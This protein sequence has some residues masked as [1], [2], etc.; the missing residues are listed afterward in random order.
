[1]DL[2]P[3]EY[4]S[5]LIIDSRDRLSGTPFDF[6]VPKNQQ[7]INMIGINR[8]AADSYHFSDILYDINLINNY[9]Q[10]TNGVN[11]YNITIPQGY[12]SFTAGGS[13]PAFDAALQTALNTGAAAIGTWTVT[14][15]QLTC[16]YTITCTNNFRILV[17]DQNDSAVLET[18]GLYT[19]SSLSTTYTTQRVLLLYSGVYYV[20]SN[21]LTRYNSRDVHTNSRIPNVLFEIS[22]GD[23]TQTGSS[24]TLK[25]E[26]TTLKIQSWDPSEPIGVVDIFILDK[27]GN[28]L[29]YDDT[30]HK[31]YFLVF[32]LKCVRKYSVQGASIKSF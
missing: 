28:K 15:I 22:I 4:I 12:Y 11:T 3:D 13:D 6:I 32:K 24:A 5:N 2:L 16:Q 14:W 18:Y 10:V 17:S 29:P 25:N 8:L 1:M 27:Y 26:F 20:C 23:Y 31:S 19:S 7:S 9:F 30:K 21:R